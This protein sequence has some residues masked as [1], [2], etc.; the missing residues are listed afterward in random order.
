[1]N[2]YPSIAHEG[3]SHAQ[4]VTDVESRIESCVERSIGVDQAVRKL[5]SMERD[6][7]YLYQNWIVM[8]LATKLAR[9]SQ[10]R[11]DQAQ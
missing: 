8:V 4:R 2:T 5:F 1:V 10:Q 11:S 9:H 3:S 7:F 6:L